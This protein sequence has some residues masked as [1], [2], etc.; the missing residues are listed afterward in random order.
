MSIERVREYLRNMNL[1]QRVWEFDASSATVELAAQALEV[2]PARIAKTL[3]FALGEGCVIIVAAG[4]ARVDN[5]KFKDQFFAKAKMLPPE[6]V[7]RFTGCEIG[8]VCPFGLPETTPVYLD[9][10]LRRF[11]TVFPACGSTNSAMEVTYGELFRYSRSAGWVDVCKDWEEGDDKRINNVPD[12][13][14]EMPSDGEITLRIASISAADETKGYVHAYKFEIV[15]LSDAAV[16]GEIDLRLGYVRNL[17]FGGN[18]GYHVNEEFRGSGY[19]GK[20][21]KLVF[22]IARRHGMPY[23]IISCRTDNLPSRRTLEKLGGT[24]LE[25]RVPASYSALYRLGERNPHCYFR[26]DL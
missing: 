14:M 21:C 2:R 6:E 9:V 11:V 16:A 1:E 8:G 20:A 19:A 4:D 5:R 25:T 18:I 17:Y 23:V 24:L 7:E 12:E 13:N 26:F 22:E 10:S 3:S 15:R